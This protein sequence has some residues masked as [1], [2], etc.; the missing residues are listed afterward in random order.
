MEEIRKE[1]K[2]L[3]G[4]TKEAIDWTKMSEDGKGLGKP[5]NSIRRNLSVI[6]ESLKKRPSIAIFGQSQVGKSYLVQNLAKPFDSQ[7]L[8]IKIAEGIEDINF[9]TDMNPGGGK[10]STGLVTRF[11]TKSIEVDKDFPFEVELF[12]Q[13]D[14]AS[15]IT[16]AFCS[17]LKDYG[18]NLNIN[19]EEIK[20]I[21][22]ELDT[23]NKQE[24]IT[25]DESF[26][27]HQYINNHFRDFSLIKDLNKI[28]FFIDLEKKLHQ[29]EFGKRV[30][31]LQY[32]WGQNK[33]LT[34]LFVRLSNGI[35]ELNFDKNVNVPLKA[36]I[37]TSQTILD[38]ER[39][40]EISTKPDD[41]LEV[42][43]SNG[44][45]KNIS[46]SI[47][48]ILTREVQLILA[49]EFNDDE[50]QSF[51]NHADLLDFPGSKSREKIPLNVF[52]NNTE[53]QKLQLLIRG[54][55]SFLF[56]SY[57]N[58]LGVSTLL[59]CMDDT[60]PEEKEAPSRLYNWIK[61]YLG[62]NQEDRTLTLSKTKEILGGVNK[63]VGIVSPLL[64]AFTK[65]N[66]ELNKVIPGLEA[67]IESHDSKWQARFEEN[68]INFMSR[69][70]E[71]KWVN[72]WTDE[73]P[74][75]KFIFPIRDPFYS[76][77][78]F[79]GFDNTGRET[80]VRP[81]RSEAMRAMETSFVGSK[82][83]NNY[84]LE[85]NEI[86]KEISNPNGTGILFLSKQL[87][88]SAHPIVTETRLN[89]ELKKAQNELFQ[90]LKPYQVSGNLNEDLK[91]AR[92]KGAK[93][94]FALTAIANKKENT[95]SSILN[96]FVISD[97]EVWNLLYDYI[98]EAS[99]DEEDE[100]DIEEIDIISSFKDFGIEL[101]AGM[102][103]NEILERLKETFSGLS[104]EE[105]EE[106]LKINFDVS[107]NEMELM[108]I[109]VEENDSEEKITN[110]II[111]YWTERIMDISLDDGIL[112]NL[113]ESQ[114]E[115]FRN[116]LSEIV[117]SKER[118]NLK[119]IISSKIRD[120]KTG[121]I[122]AE[123]LDLVAS[124][125][126][127]T[128]NK[129][130]FTGGWAFENEEKKPEIQ[131][132]LRIFSEHGRDYETNDL[133]YSAD[134]NKDFFK[135]WNLGIKELYEANVRYNYNLGDKTINAVANQKL[136]EILINLQTN[137]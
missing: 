12:S 103:K 133:D 58:R 96:N 52:E 70:V 33:F 30:E 137:N 11:T 13:L 47:L 106:E 43:L 38:V 120:I 16:N 50:P 77:A 62:Q 64:V 91:E 65:F 20:S 92:R 2:R 90:I 44:R 68:F 119:R 49:H 107:L 72:N 69:P 78:T 88:N 124:C 21:W 23:G 110:I 134:N 22:D 5:I 81:E 27:F 111:P 48:G 116:L 118:L 54:K 132:D 99:D 34:Q 129:F 86:W 89:I 36:L 101:S 28:G 104:D 98:F 40:R 97:T 32:L 94:S 42:K 3:L 87:K 130:L 74:Y 122:G 4:I 109:P 24:G 67:N 6:D 135:Q 63:E 102:T 117:K 60:P 14:I 53:E 9:L 121:T 56:D 75:F 127:T 8:K 55:V 126:T 25:P 82:L 76:Q 45:V 128:L 18:N 66:V 35:Q 125:S 26:F 15:I 73:N 114:K 29:I 31:I 113:N 1:T 39:I 41:I 105:I 57:T 123:D 37:P 112:R 95:L 46:R 17:D 115:V 59:Y 51:L 61:K 19:Q 83:V 93:S 84:T 131:G 136:D 108:L 7:F 100:S 85:T 79:D 10:E 80:Q 71:D